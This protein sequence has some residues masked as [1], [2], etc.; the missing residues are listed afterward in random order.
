MLPAATAEDIIQYVTDCV[1]EAGSN[2]CPPVVVGVGLGSDFEGVALLAK[3]AL[4]RDGANPDPYYAEMESAMLTAVNALGVGPQ[5]FGG[6]C[7]ALAVHI[8]AAPT[9][10]AGLPVAVNVGCHVTR[11]KSVTL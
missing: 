4:C 7:T 5:G 8:E 3:R 11:H 9:H 6:D 10:I 1:R 2:P